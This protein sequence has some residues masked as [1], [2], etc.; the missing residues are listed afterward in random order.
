VG[1]K[2]KVK[3]GQMAG[4][5]FHRLYGYGYVKVA[6][7]NGGRRVI[8]ENE[9]KWVRQIYQWLVNDGLSTT[10]ITYRL[11]GLNA[12]TKEGGLW[13]RAAVLN[14]LKN[15]AYT[16]KTY[17][18]TTIGHKPFSRKQEEWVEIPDVTP[19]LISQEMFDFAQKQLQI[20]RQNASRNVRR[21][22]LLRG[23]IRCR[24]CERAYYGCVTNDRIGGQHKPTRRYH[25]SGK[26]KMVAPVNRCPNKSWQ[27]EKLE[28][29]VWAQ[30]ERVLGNPSLIITEINK[31]RE[32]INQ[33]SLLE[34][35]LKQVEKHLKALDRDQEQLLQWALKGFPEETVVAENKRINKRRASLQTQKA[36]LET[37]I[38]AG[39]EASAS[40]PKLERFIELM[41]EKL[42][43]L[44]F[45][46]KR[47]ALEMLNI[48]V[49]IDGHNVEITGTVP[50]ADDVIVTTQS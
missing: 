11:R 38:K 49:W 18:F 22:Y 20:N 15:P 32:D 16:G 28:A 12:P 33:L 1:K 3:L 31:Q 43:M 13:C 41:R 40:L 14:I 39:Q 10:A 29:L 8:N 36:E 42:T 23:H 45:E 47:M 5:G 46:T 27:A 17:A 4:G 35:E 9:A 7:N 50:I 44:D 34:D 24:Q 19:P 37:Q 30:I 21:Q 48:K 25:C 26:L 6:D 2:A